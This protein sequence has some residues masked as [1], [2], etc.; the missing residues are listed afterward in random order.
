MSKTCRKRGY[1]ATFIQYNGKNFPEVSAMMAEAGAKVNHHDENQVM[2]RTEAGIET[3][4]AGDFVVRGENG[5][6][7][8]YVPASFHIK[9]EE[10]A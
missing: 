2:I 7:K 10:I 9:Y 1:K 8:T 6:V 3:L 5:V 4:R